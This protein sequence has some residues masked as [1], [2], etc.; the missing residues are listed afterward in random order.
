MIAAY[1]YLNAALYLIFAV[2][3][4]LSPWKTATALGFESLANSGRSEFLVIYGGLQLG[5]AAF[6][7]W[8]AMSESTQRVG[9]IFALCLYAPLVLYRVVTVV[10]FWPVKG[11][12]VG[13]GCLEASLLIAAIIGTMVLSRAR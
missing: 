6:F 9:L 13:V 8:T 11:L 4:T 5:L 3:Q 12:T 2:W 7:A 10:K 1:L